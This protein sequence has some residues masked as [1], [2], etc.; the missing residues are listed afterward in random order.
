MDKQLVVVVDELIDVKVLPQ[1]SLLVGNT[2]LSI[3][4]YPTLVQTCQPILLELKP[5]IA[6][7]SNIFARPD[8]SPIFIFG[9][10]FFHSFYTVFDREKK[11]IGLYTKPSNAV[12]A[13]QI[14]LQVYRPFPDSY[15]A[16]R[17][18]PLKTDIYYW[19]YYFVLAAIGSFFLLKLVQQLLGRK[20][21]L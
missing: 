13:S 21:L 2:R 1:V 7:F 11:R 3:D 14:D 12:M 10:P 5:K 8:G 15:D 20:R 16:G 4:F 6:C 18:V 17:L 9:L 19:L